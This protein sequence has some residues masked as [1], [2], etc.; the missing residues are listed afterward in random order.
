MVIDASAVIAEI[1]DEPGAEMIRNCM[2]T[3]PEGGFF[4]HA[5]NVCEVAYHLI[6]SGLHESIAYELAIPDGVAIV[7]DIR[8]ALW[9]RAA[10][11]KARY[12][13]LALGDCIAIALAESLN[14]DVLTGDRDFQNV[15]TEVAV[16]LFR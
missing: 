12:K 16:K 7:D 14:A 4:M 8:P 6:K 5:I 1:K 2:M 11:L 15:D 10:S 13:N 3:P 9:K